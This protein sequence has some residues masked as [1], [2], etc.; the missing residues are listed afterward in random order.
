[1][2][3]IRVRILRKFIDLRGLSKKNIPYDEIIRLE[4]LVAMCLIAF[5]CGMTYIIVGLFVGL[6]LLNILNY[7]IFFLTTIPA[8]LYLTKKGLYNPAKLIMMVLGSIFMVIKASSIGPDSGMNLSMLIILFATF[9]FYSIEDYK[10]I[11]LSLGLILVSIFFLEFTNYSY[12]GIDLSTNNYEYGFNYLSTILFCILFFYVILRVNQYMNKKLSKLNQKLS[13]KN[14]KLAKTNEEL[15][16]YMYKASHDMRAPITSM[17]GILSLMKLEKDPEK[18]NHLI[19]LQSSCLTKLDN[20]IHQIINLS[21][22][23]KTESTREKID[24]KDMI[25]EI[26]EELS[27]FEN[28]ANT[29]KLIKIEQP[30]DFY[31]DPYRLKM[32]VNNLVTNAFKYARKD[33]PLPLIKIDA[34]IS[35]VSA[36]IT[37]RDNGIG[38][39]ENQQSKIFGMF[40]RGTEIS[41]GSGLGLYMVKEMVD[42]LNGTI[43]VIS[44]VDHFTSITFVVPNNLR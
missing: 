13:A 28:A 44:E 21:K 11:L 25:N 4:L 6:S 29:K 43:S 3:F 17:M 15:D 23:L 34:L 12:L 37:I 22:N 30:I 5:T 41:K 42:K 24:L 18:E 26:F 40:Y 35:S 16:S 9:A 39:P 14:R 27:F 20:H 10:Y 7:L 32:I 31:S 8:V 36:T 1:M 38:I 19:E 33:E 2:K